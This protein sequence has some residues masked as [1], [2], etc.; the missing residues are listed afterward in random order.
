MPALKPAYLIHGDDH[1]AVI[2][3]RM[4]LRALVRGAG[5]AMSMESFS[6]QSSSPRAAA[7]RLGALTLDPAHR[8]LIFEDVERWKEKEIKE[9]LLPAL[10]CPPERT[11]LA[12]FA[13]EEGRVKVAPALI[14]AVRACSGQVA[15]ERRLALGALVRW[16]ISEAQGQGLALD[17]EGARTLIALVGERRAQL[18]RALELLALELRPA[19]GQ[20]AAVKLAPEQIEA[21]VA[22]GGA[23]AAYALADALLAGDRRLAL[24]T[25]SRLRAH[26][27]RPGA[28]IYLLAARLRSALSA[29]E[30]LAAGQSPA[31]IRPSLRMPTHAAQE[32]I[33]N[34]RRI[35]PGALRQGLCALADLEAHSRGGAA[36]GDGR[37]APPALSEETLAQLAIERIAQACAA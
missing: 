14:A 37:S 22:G 30:R 36:L 28:L 24:A 25:Y 2:E 31:A 11:T 32:L 5:E 12:L 21:R 1:G 29:A 9:A 10:G 19:G 18:V 20:D 35:G 34:A 4:R 3:R 6:G 33:A 27:E 7:E 26:G 16:V 17:A 13:C 15:C 23:A 8:V